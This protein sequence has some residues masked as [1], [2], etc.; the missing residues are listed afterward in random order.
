MQFNL[1]LSVLLVLL[2]WPVLFLL[3]PEGLKGVRSDSVLLLR[4][5]S[6]PVRHF[7][8]LLQK[9]CE[10]K[11]VPADGAADIPTGGGTVTPYCAS[12][13]AIRKNGVPVSASSYPDGQRR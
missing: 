8:L 11:E 4:V 5:P 2:R 7:P 13:G 6:I 1:F 12:S 3:F 9:E 10:R